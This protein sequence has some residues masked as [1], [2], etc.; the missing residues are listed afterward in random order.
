MPSRYPSCASHP[1]PPH[2]A[3]EY[4]VDK[5]ADDDA[6]DEEALEAPAFGARARDDRRGRVHERHHVEE[7]DDDGTVIGIGAEEEAFEA[8]E[9]PAVIAGDGRAE[10]QHAVH[11]RQ[12]TKL[13][14]PTDGG[15]VEAAAHEGKAT[16]EEAEHA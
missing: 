9:T 7:H 14:R 3:G 1:P 15:T 6:E 11:R 16:D 10:G 12:P 2:P 13:S 4:G 5:S 8:E